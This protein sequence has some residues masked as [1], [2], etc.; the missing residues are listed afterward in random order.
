[1]HRQA[2]PVRQGEKAGGSA[3]TRQACSMNRES[4]QW[5]IRAM[6]CAKGMACMS[7]ETARHVA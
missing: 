4:I 3:C 5:G 6:K 7:Q 2:K 1:M